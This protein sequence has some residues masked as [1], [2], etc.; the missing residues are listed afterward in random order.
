MCYPFASEIIVEK[1]R[2]TEKVAIGAL[3]Q[4]KEIGG[5]AQPMKKSDLRAEPSKEE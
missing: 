1:Q 5:I 4:V 2:S 3:H